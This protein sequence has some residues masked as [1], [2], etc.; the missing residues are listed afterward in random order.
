MD[1]SR[2]WGSFKLFIIFLQKDFI[3]KKSIK[4]HKKHKKAQKITKS[5]KKYKTETSDFHLDAHKKH[6]KVQNT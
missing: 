2:N 5:T 3:R 4:R 6:K 1:M